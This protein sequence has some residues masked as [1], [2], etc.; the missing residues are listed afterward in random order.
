MLLWKSYFRELLQVSPQRVSCRVGS[1]E[2]RAAASS[3]SLPLFPPIGGPR[4][5]AAKPE[6]LIR[7]M[8]RTI[9]HELPAVA[10]LST[11]TQVETSQTSSHQLAEESKEWRVRREMG[12]GR[13][14][15]RTE[16][17]G[18]RWS[19]RLHSFSFIGG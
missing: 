1:A 19:F 16:G 15:E 12:H 14:E 8:S 4:S 17:E 11:V 10:N 7:W 6:L 3:R 13:G 9:S 18:A 5:A 2:S